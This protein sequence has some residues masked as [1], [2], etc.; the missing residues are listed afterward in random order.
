MVN[1]KEKGRIPAGKIFPKSGEIP[2]PNYNN[3]STFIPA[4]CPRKIL[5]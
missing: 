4:K 2:G 5:T 3:S 1:A